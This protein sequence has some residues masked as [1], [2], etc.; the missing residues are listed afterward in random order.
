MAALQPLLI[1][2]AYVV[3]AIGV[4]DGGLRPRG[5]KVRRPSG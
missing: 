2:I 1:D 5:A 3:V 4:T